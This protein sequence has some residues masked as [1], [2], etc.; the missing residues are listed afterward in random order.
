MKSDNAEDGAHYRG[1]AAWSTQFYARG[2][3]PKSKLRYKTH[4]DPLVPLLWCNYYRSCFKC[5]HRV[6]RCYDTSG[7][8]GAFWLSGG[9]TRRSETVERFKAAVLGRRAYKVIECHR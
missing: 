9:D 4:H 7:T 3:I 2:N 1:A 6:G 8:E 5:T